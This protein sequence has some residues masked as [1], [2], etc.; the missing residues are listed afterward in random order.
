MTRNEKIVTPSRVNLGVI[1][2]PTRRHETST[3]LKV[4]SNKILRDIEDHLTF[5]KRFSPGNVHNI[6]TNCRRL[7]RDFGVVKPCI[8]D[9]RR[10]EELLRVQGNIQ[11]STIRK[12]LRAM[13]LMSEAQGL[14]L[15]IKKPKPVYR[16]RENLSIPEARGVLLSAGN[17]RDR[18]IIALLLFCGLR[19]G[20]LVNLKLQDVDLTGRTI[21]VR[22]RTKN[23]YERRALMARECAELL[24]A[25][26]LIRPEMPGNDSLFLNVR[27]GVLSGHRVEEVVH[28][29]GV[30]A[31]IG[32]RCYPH[33]LR[34]TAASAM[35]K[36][37]ITLPEVALQLGH[38]SLSSTMLYLHGDLEG[39][40]DSIDK[41][42]KY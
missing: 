28:D 41:R 37:G 18:A 42:F 15:H 13:E 29:A 19:C 35:L 7:V 11:D 38:R 23:R 20:E 6:M 34:H 2:Q 8:E 30:R 27:G 17:V 16:I 32:K 14:P 24:E 36:S 4:D 26:M 5:E 22:G 9:A 39:L 33:M 40:R 12:Y 25:W 1:E 10:V 31:G 3:I 21:T